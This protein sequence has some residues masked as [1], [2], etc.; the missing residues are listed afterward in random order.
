MRRPLR[1]R[2]GMDSNSVKKSRSSIEN[3]RAP[4]SPSAGSGR[5]TEFGTAVRSTRLYL[6][7]CFQYGAS[8]LRAATKKFLWRG[9][10][11][12]PGPDSSGHSS[13][14]RLNREE[15]PDES[16]MARLK[17]TRRSNKC[18]RVAKVT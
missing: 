12:L 11:S 18:P 10:S 5:K 15:F 14:K 6:D 4:D 17:A 16:D 1:S 13:S 2:T 7:A 3:R 8:R 9:L